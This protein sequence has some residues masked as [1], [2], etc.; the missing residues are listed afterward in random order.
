V[1]GVAVAGKVS[2]SAS[3]GRHR[4]RRRCGSATSRPVRGGNMLFENDGKGHFK[5]SP[6]PPASDYVG[7]SSSA[8]FFDYDRDGKLDLFLSTSEVHDEPDRGGRY[9]VLR[10]H[11]QGLRRPSEAGAWP[12]RASCTT[13]KAQPVSSTSRRGWASGISPGRATPAA[14]RRQRRRLAGSLRA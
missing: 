3:F 2:V 8:V 4:Q 14:G 13:T 11:R 12:S 1:A 7:H 10:R 6:R 5:T 9:I